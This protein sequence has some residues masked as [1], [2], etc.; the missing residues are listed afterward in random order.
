M[1]KRSVAIL[2]EFFEALAVL[3][4]LDPID[5]SLACRF[6]SRWKLSIADALL[7]LNF[8]D[9]TSLAKA[10]AHAHSLE[11]LPWSELH[12]D[13]SEID[14]EMF[15]DLLSVGAAM[16]GD[17]RLAICN[18]YDDLRG[19]LGKRLCQREM[20]VTERSHLYDA[21]RQQGLS[22]WLEGDSS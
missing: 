16:L 19:N 10:L 6:A 7:D 4:D 14:F 1:T 3:T 17:G 18:P 5:W 8:V 15:Q 2:P 22:N 20:V 9:E 21:L 13:F 11:Y 12:C